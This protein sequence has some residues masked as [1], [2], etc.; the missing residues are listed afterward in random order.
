MRLD[1]IAY[2]VKDREITARFFEEAFGFQTGEAF[3]I[4]FEDGTCARCI[5]MV[6][7][8]RNLNHLFPWTAMEIESTTQASQEYHIAPE[9]FISDGEPDSVVG[10]WVAARNGV[11]GIH[12]LAYQVDSVEAKMQEW[13]EK[14][15]AEFTTQDPLTCPGLTQ[16]FTQPSALTGVI[17]EFIEREPQNQ[18]FCKDNVKD[19]MNS[20]KDLR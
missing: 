19:L 10:K 20:T 5:A 3:Q 1:H 16:A 13:R 9:V 12:H 18:G 7:P 6:P 2:R 4:D 8:E 15:Y 14:G 17:Y 11:G